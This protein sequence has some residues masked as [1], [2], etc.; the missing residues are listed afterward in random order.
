MPLILN[1]DGEVKKVS[2]KEY[3]AHYS[4]SVEYTDKPVSKVR[5]V[6]KEYNNKIRLSVDSIDVRTD[7]DDDGDK[8][9]N[10]GHPKSSIDSSP[11]RQLNNE[12]KEVV[13]IN[14]LSLKEHDKTREALLFL[15]ARETGSI[16]I[17]DWDKSGV[18]GAVGQAFT[19]RVFLKTNKC[20]N[21]TQDGLT[22]VLLPTGRKVLAEA[23]KIVRLR[24]NAEEEKK[25]KASF[26][27]KWSGDRLNIIIRHALKD[28]KVK[29]HSLRMLMK[30]QSIEAI[31]RM[32]PETADD[33][34][35]NTLQEI[36]RGQIETQLE[37]K[38]G[39]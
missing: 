10:G 5:D 2:N 23:E 29:N 20:I 8:N 7:K 30:E 22:A 26:V 32:K 15:A 13:L 38:L 16:A 1:D 37:K 6:S 3:D 11:L 12:E 36:I 39:R 31:Q 9:G 27:K 33:E 14:L 19:K 28:T 4:R 25:M 21:Y 18:F 24:K 17:H 34:V 35:I